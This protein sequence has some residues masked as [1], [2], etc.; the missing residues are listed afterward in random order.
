ML[1]ETTRLIQNRLST[2][3]R[4]RLRKIITEASEPIAP[5]WPMRTMVAQNPI[6]GL[7]Y[8][9]FD[10]AVRQGKI[11]LG[12]NGYLP[13]EEYRQLYQEGRISSDSIK[14]AFT[15]TGPRSVQQDTC[16]IGNRHISVHIVWQLHLLFGFEGLPP[17][18]LEWELSE[19]GTTRQFHQNLPEPSRTQIIDRTI[20]ECELCRE[21]P[22][23]AYLANLWKSTVATLELSEAPS[24]VQKTHHTNLTSL[25][26]QPS[27]LDISL[28]DQQTMSDWVGNLTSTDLLEQID[29]QLMKWV[30]AFLDEGLAE[31]EMPEREKGFYQAWRQLLGEDY[32][33]TLLGIKNIAQKYFVGSY[34]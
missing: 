6:H 17:S 24:D 23:K 4:E 32:T 27:V 28:H 9:P 31:W 12:G 22:E 1:S 20:K 7:E 34:Q 16:K 15:R 2:E 13:N 19:D 8:L 18:L 21:Y 5:F 10:E 14:R 30:A 11:L 26:S 29:S 3:E 33:G 25:E